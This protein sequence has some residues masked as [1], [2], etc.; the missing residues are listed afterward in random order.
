MSR[1]RIL[2]WIGA[3][4][5]SL[6]ASMSVGY[7]QEKSQR[8]DVRELVSVLDEIRSFALLR[9]LNA[10]PTVGD[11]LKC[12]AGCKEI[13]PG[14]GASQVECVKGCSKTSSPTEVKLFAR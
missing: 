10:G 7:A 3:I 2:A 8:D 11:Y 4:V 5:F 6:V 13:F 1:I 12:V 14:G 9:A